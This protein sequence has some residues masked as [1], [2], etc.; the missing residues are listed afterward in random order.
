ME[1][2]GLKVSGFWSDDVSIL[3]NAFDAEFQVT[4]DSALEM[5]MCSCCIILACP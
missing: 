4:R 5:R 2:R 3:Q 1:A